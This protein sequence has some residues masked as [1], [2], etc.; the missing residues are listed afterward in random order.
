MIDQQD[1]NGFTLIEV[2]VALTIFSIS[3]AVLLTVFSDSLSRFRLNE[4]R[5]GAE[6]HARSILAEIGVTR[7]LQL[8]EAS[9]QV[10][11]GYHWTIK[12]TPYGSEDDRAAWPVEAVIVRLS[13]WKEGQD[14]RPV[15]VTTMKFM[16]RDIP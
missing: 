12:T 2:L 3:I 9:G 14:N 4:D 13:V 16:D 10:E 6:A 15:E 8:G 11:G 7:Q 1:Q 5:S